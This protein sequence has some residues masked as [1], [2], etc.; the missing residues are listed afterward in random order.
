[1]AVREL[2]GIEVP[3]YWREGVIKFR[4]SVGQIYMLGDIIEVVLI[5]WDE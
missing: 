1:M 2:W 5:H 3:N 4:G